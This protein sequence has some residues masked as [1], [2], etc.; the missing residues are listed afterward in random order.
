[1]I[2]YEGG[3]QVI[4]F[5]V[6]AT[7][8]SKDDKRKTIIGTPHYM[9][10][11]L[12]GNM[13]ASNVKYGFE[14]SNDQSFLS[15]NFPRVEIADSTQVDIWSYMCTIY[16]IATGKPP[17]PEMRPGR[18][19][20]NEI[21]R[22]PPRLDPERFSPELCEFLAYLSRPKPE[23]RPSFN[24]IL[25]HPYIKDSNFSHPST[26]LQEV[27]TNFS[28]WARRGGQRESLFMEYGAAA[29]TDYVE[30]GQDGDGESFVWSEANELRQSLGDIP[31]SFNYLQDFVQPLPTLQV[32]PPPGSTSDFENG[33][34]QREP[35]RFDFTDPDPRPNAQEHA[36]D[37]SSVISDCAAPLDVQRVQQTEGNSGLLETIFDSNQ[38]PYEYEFRAQ[39]MLLNRPIISRVQ[40][41]LPLRNANPNGSSELQR[42]E[43]DVDGTPSRSEVKIADANTIKQNRKEKTNT[44]MWE[45]NWQPQ[46]PQNP[47]PEGP[48]AMSRPILHHAETFSGSFSEH[49]NVSRQTMDLDA[50]MGDM[51]TPADQTT[52]SQTSRQTIDL[53]ALMNTLPRSATQP[54]PNRATM[55]L[56][57]M[58]GDDAWPSAAATPTAQSDPTYHPPPPTLSYTHISPEADTSDEETP[59][60]SMRQHLDDDSYTS[61]AASNPYTLRPSHSTTRSTSTTASN[62]LGPYQPPPNS[63]AALNGPRTTFPMPAVPAFDFE[64]DVDPPRQSVMRDGASN[65]ELADELTRMLEGN[66]G[67]LAAF[68]REMPTGAGGEGEEYLGEDEGENGGL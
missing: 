46:F 35:T 16:E 57:A 42:K 9:G 23:D 30:E 64:R 13:A 45:A 33:G 55:D 59:H 40:S 26:L 12:I 32:D 52:T 56:D 66:M 50:L 5:G 37:S 31:A 17:N 10:P 43:V 63:A 20:Q 29:S 58:M 2:S 14:V 22:N 1:M 49:T 19:M 7:L 51:S 21:R 65:E 54:T 44:M 24:D 36:Q 68:E 48:T 62:I 11:E 3:V 28:V 53:D 47:M 67:A 61:L 15:R 25:D 4:D 39:G 6:A 60:K 34:S 8:G 18:Q 41:D 38:G 27:V